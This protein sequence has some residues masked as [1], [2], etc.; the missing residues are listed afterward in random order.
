M[1]DHNSV[2]YEFDENGDPQW[3][4][5][6]TNDPDGIAK[7]NIQSL[8][9]MSVGSINYMPTD[10]TSMADWA[11]D[12]LSIWMENKDD[13]YDIPV[14]ATFTSEESERYN[15]LMGEISTHYNE[16]VLRRITGDQNLSTYNSFIQELQS[17]GIEECIELKQSMLDRYNQR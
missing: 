17:M 16:T 12:A 7:M 8:Y 14:T 2:T 11:V 10:T 13:A 5:F 9:T 15:E 1:L 4:D 3:T 6:V